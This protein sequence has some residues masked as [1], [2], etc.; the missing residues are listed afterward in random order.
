MEECP[1]C[2]AKD[3]KQY[4]GCPNYACGSWVDFQAKLRRHSKCYEAQLRILKG[5]LGEVE[6]ALEAISIYPFEEQGVNIHRLVEIK[7]TA[8]ALLA[9][10]KGGDG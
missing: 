5:L 6:K 7:E 9:R 3:R 8:Q 10:I 4:P 2:G 1:F